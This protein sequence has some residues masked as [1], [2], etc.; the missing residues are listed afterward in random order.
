[1][2]TTTHPSQE[3]RSLSADLALS[4]VL[5][6]IVE[7]SPRAGHLWRE[8]ARRLHELVDDIEEP[9]L[10]AIAADPEFLMLLREFIRD[11]LPP[12]ATP[13]SQS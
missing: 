6:R 1:V 13:S 3:Q 2:A 9:D 12:P 7:R 10:D 11:L 8:I 4:L 5:R